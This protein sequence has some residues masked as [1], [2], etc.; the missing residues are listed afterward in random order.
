MGQLVDEGDVRVA[1]QHPVEIHLGQF[2]AAT[3]HIVPRDDLQPLGHRR[4]GYPAVSLDNGD[5]DV[6][7]TSAEVLTLVKHGVGL[8]DARCRAQQHPQP[9]RGS[10]LVLLSQSYP[11]VN[12]VSAGDP[13]RH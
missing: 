2:H 3:L 5:N 1:S 6:G 9:S 7:P 11:T 10:H 13:V 4:G 12:T 8:T